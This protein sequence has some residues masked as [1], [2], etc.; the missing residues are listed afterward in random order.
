MA[1]INEKDFLDE[2][3]FCINESDIIKVQ[4]LL[5]YFPG[6]KPDTQNTVLYKISQVRGKMFYLMIEFIMQID[7]KND[8]VREKISQVILNKALKNKVFI[9]NL[10]KNSS[11]MNLLIL[12]KVIQDIDYKESLDELIQLLSIEKNVGVLAEIVKAISFFKDE[13]TLPLIAE[14]AFS[15]DDFLAETA[16]LSVGSFYNYK[17]LE[18]LNEIYLVESLSQDLKKKTKISILDT[19]TFFKNE[20]DDLKVAVNKEDS[21]KS[22]DIQTLLT[23]SDFHTKYDFIKLP[24]ELNS[25]L[26][27]KISNLITSD[28]TDL[29]INL[30][31]I[32]NGTDDT[33]VFK[34]VNKLLYNQNL[35]DHMKLFL[36]ELIS[37]NKGFESAM[38]LVEELTNTNELIRFAAA[39]ALNSNVTDIIVA[40]IRNRIETTGTT[41]K[42]ITAAIIDSRSDVIFN[43]LLK[44]DT[45][46]ELATYHISEKTSPEIYDHYCSFLKQKKLNYILRHIRKRSFSK[47]KQPE[48]IVY[49]IHETPFINHW[50]SLVLY[51]N[52]FKSVCFTTISEAINNFASFTPDFIFTDL[53]SD[54][55]NGI[56]FS[57]E[58]KKVF[59]INLVI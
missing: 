9:R 47:I 10:L 8:D 25:E 58:I 11:S 17:A 42:T 55:I 20:Q 37:R 6:I 35:P 12:L 29:L 33:L 27:D 34:S 7:I 56:L 32:L 54:E 28:N 43:K 23:T 1:G 14:F 36:F 41:P 59:H 2:L 52:G 40:G 46:I 49:I 18:I 22:P 50:I 4:A 24:L 48:K 26:T 45:F 5:Q 15:K 16:I 44:S 13:N 3:L 21:E 57:E 39:A 19:E 31:Q 53:Y 38:H 30:L 51:K